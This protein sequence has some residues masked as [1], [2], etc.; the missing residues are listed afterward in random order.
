MRNL[1]Q[2]RLDY[3]AALAKRL[4]RLHTRHTFK[5]AKSAADMLYAN[6]LNSAVVRLASVGIGLNAERTDVTIE[7]AVQ[8]H[9][10]AQYVPPKV[11]G[12]DV[13]VQVSGNVSAY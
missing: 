9:A 13:N 1:D 7:V 5:Q 2:A 3:E 8:D 10:S 6:L 12:I 11:N 4:E